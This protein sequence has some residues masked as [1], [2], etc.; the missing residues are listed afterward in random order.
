MEGRNIL[1]EYLHA[2]ILACLQRAG[3]MILVAFHGGTSLRFLFGSLR[4]SEDLH[5]TLE[6][7]RSLYD[8]RRYL[9]DIQSTFSAETYVT[10]IKVNDKK[11]VQHAFIRFPGLLH[12]LDLSTHRQEI[13][14]VKI[15]V[16][17]NPPAGAG[18]ETS[19]VRRHETLQIHHHDKASLLA[20]KL[21]AILQRS[22]TKGRDIYDLIWYLS[23]PD[24]PSPN[25]TLLNNALAQSG[26]NRGPLSKENWRDVVRSRLASF[27]WKRVP[28]DVRP[29]LER[30]DEADLLTREN[31]ERLL[32]PS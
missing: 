28:D 5:F 16:D 12:E 18:L 32:S 25:V 4:Y 3:A 24:W 23:D 31:L 21:H 20:G 2:R 17:T 14:S 10:E 8:F 13:I 30:Q 15:E 1:R 11:T 22:Y 7:D 26:W 27:D 6:G 19:V 9:A 29:F